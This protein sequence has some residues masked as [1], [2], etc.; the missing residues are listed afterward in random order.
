MTRASLVLAALLFA[1]P[2]FAQTT[3]AGDWELTIQSPTG[4]RSMPLTLKQEGETVTGL[5][6]GPQGEL[7]VKGTFI[8]D[9]LKFDFSIPIQ[10]SSID[11]S[12]SGKVANETVSG[13]AQFGGFGEGPFT[14]K[15]P[16]QTASATATPAPTPTDPGA[17][18]PTTTD[19][20][21]P[22]GL[23]GGKWD[24]TIKTPGGDFP[25]T[26]NFTEDG[27]KLT[28]TFGSQMGEVPVIGTIEGKALK[29]SI[30]AKTPQGEITV[31]LSG[32][33]DGDSIVNGKADIAG[34]GQMEW[35][36]KRAKQ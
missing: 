30:V 14:M 5:F 8:G 3:V 15:R 17:A 28:G 10:G 4:T 29:L 7:P 9:E 26:A 35:T 11:I 20:P 33:V 27:G 19:P 36:A 2:T 21:V 18:V 32:D 6:K 25:A 1:V 16:D 12:M 22:A 31:E 13:T 23:A 24:V 34:M